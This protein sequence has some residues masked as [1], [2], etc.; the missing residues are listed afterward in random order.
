MIDCYPPDNNQY[1]SQYAAWLEPYFEVQTV[2][3]G[4]LDS[5][6]IS[7]D[8]I[9]LSGSTLMLTSQ[10]MPEPLEKLLLETDKPLLGVC[11]GHQ[12]LAQAWGAK[13]V[14]KEMF[15]AEAT[16]RTN[17]RYGLI[18]E[19]GLFFNV[20]ESHSVHIVNN[21]KLK[22]NFEVLAYSDSCDVE[23]IKHKERPLWGVQFHPERSDPV[24]R[25]I[26][27]KL[28]EMVSRQR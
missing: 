17:N 8:C 1:F 9:V 4:K 2:E 7:Q 18:E 27:A 10:S 13:L 11:Y 14:K 15:E 12:A 5:T 23:V 21:R 6:R 22:K 24:G 28:A 3:A 16:I 19:L 26:A 20:A 25:Q